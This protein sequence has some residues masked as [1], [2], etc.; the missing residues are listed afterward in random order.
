[1][2]SACW[3][4]FSGDVDDPP[5][6]EAPLNE[7]TMN[8]GLRGRDIRE[9]FKTDEFSIL[10]VANK[11]QTGF[12]QPLLCAMYVD[13]MLG[14]IQAVQT[15]SRLNRAH[16]G[17]DATFV[18]DFVNDRQDV[19]AAFKQYHA[20]AELAD[21]SNPNVV[22]DLK[23]K[24]DATGRYDVFEVE[25]VAAVVVDP[26]A[27]Q[28]QLDAAISPVSSRLLTRYKEA[29]LAYQAAAEG[30]AE[31][32]RAKGE[33]DALLLFRA[34]LGA[35]V[36]AYEFMG[37]MFDYG[38][39]Y[40]E[41]LQLFARMLV[42]L[43]EFGRER[44]GVDLSALR[45]T[46]HRMRDLGQQQVNLAGGDA[47]EPL[48]PVTE[49]GSG[50]VQ[51]KHKLRLAE[52]IRAIND[53]FEGDITDGDAVAYHEVLGAKMLESE[54]LRQQAAANSKQQFSSSPDLGRELTNAIMDAMSAHQEMSRQALGS[55]GIRARIL[56][57]LL[58]PGE[59]WQELRRAP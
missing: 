45:L 35:Y 18:V 23:A 37:Q 22:L 52:I 14:G 29:R 26:K 25:R 31:Q 53:L 33:G 44:D 49:A 28:G 43:L 27:T 54:T 48:Q 20:T 30:S 6:G 58:G 40:Y 32:G 39:T 51:D 36:R 57:T 50:S 11:F 24:L 2:R 17:K 59:L 15:L 56:A 21:V 3:W 8:P 9:A 55:E 16:P 41:K 42:P 19:L 4:R 5:S 1:M 7:Q 13:R 12:D 34:D 38:N 10:I 47:A 46:H